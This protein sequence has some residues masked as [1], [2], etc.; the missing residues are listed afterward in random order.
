[1]SKAPGQNVQAVISWCVRSHSM[2]AGCGEGGCAVDI[3]QWMWGMLLMWVSITIGTGI[4]LYR[5]RRSWM[6]KYR[7]DQPQ[8]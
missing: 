4:R 2:V 7:E 3:P 5:T 6:R 1:M 8:S